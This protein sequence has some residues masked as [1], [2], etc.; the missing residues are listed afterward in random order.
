MNDKFLVSVDNISS[1]KKT[2]T[3]DTMSDHEDSIVKI[4][5]KTIRRE[6]GLIF[7]AHHAR[8]FLQQGKFANR[9]R[10]DTSLTLAAIT[11]YLTMELLALSGQIAMK[12]GA[13]RIQ[14]R[15]LFLAVHLDDEFRELLS[16]ITMVQGGAMPRASH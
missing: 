14:P 5:R 2:T 8:K 12:S 6:T 16:H 15:H 13:K 3:R 7:P 4:K 10:R 9:I 1:D 11:Q